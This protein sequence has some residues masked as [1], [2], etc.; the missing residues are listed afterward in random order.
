MQ[1]LL[2]V[3]VFLIPFQRR[4]YKH[5]KSISSSLISSDWSLPAYFEIHLDWYVTD[6]L[7][8]ALIL[9]AF[10]VWKWHE[11]FW[12]S[13]RK[14][15][16]L[17]LLIAL[18]SI[19]F[20]HHPTYPLHYWRWLHLALP[21][22][23]C[24]LIRPETTLPALAKTVLASSLLECAIAIPQYFVQHSL[25]LKWLGEQT[26]ISRHFVG[27]SFPMTD[28]T[29]SWFDR[30]FHIVRDHDF[31]IRAYGTLPHPN[32]LGGV[33]VF[34]LLMTYYL[35]S[36]GKRRGWLA[37]AIAI[38]VFCLIITY[39]RAALYAWMIA[40]AIW[41][42]LEAIQTRK[43]SR[44]MW[45]VA[46]SLVVSFACFY[47]QLLERGGVVSYNGVTQASDAGRKMLNTVG[48]AMAYDHPFWGVGFN[49]YHLEFSRYAEVEEIPPMF[50][51]N[52]YVL[53][54]AEIGILGLAAFLLFCFFVI[55]RGWEQRHQPH[56]RILFVLFLALL[57]IGLVD[58]YPLYNQ[59]MR[60][61]FF[62]TSGLLLCPAAKIVG[63]DM[64]QPSSSP[65]SI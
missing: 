46:G 49:N 28:E 23:L 45:I 10:R 51:H 54:A 19:A 65:I 44:L 6:F 38:Q 52:V 56:S 48:L 3:L 37:A 11:M 16:T 7:L 20:S 1:R 13:E 9:G 12:K 5:L 29:V 53:M 33:M 63:N 61:I 21:A 62:L 22:F 42:V 17:F 59:Q 30:L 32:I 64:R 14:Y 15:L 57:G 26:L 60:L 2:L 25:G 39:S 41:L 8:M 27:A 47:S 58:Y 55:K 34:G 43:I 24:F 18:G 40:T 4:F 31:V 35:F 50:V 36:Q